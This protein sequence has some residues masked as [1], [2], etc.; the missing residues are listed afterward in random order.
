MALIEP[1]ASWRRLVEAADCLLASM[2]RDGAGAIV[3]VAAST[4]AAP[5][6]FTCE[7]LVDAFAFLRRLGLVEGG[8]PGR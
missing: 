3:E 5:G 1:G 6:I 8:A 2:R 4:Q 7:E